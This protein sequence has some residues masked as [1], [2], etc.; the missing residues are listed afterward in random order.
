MQEHLLL[1]CPL[2]ATKGVFLPIQSLSLVE[3]VEIKRN[4]VYKD[5]K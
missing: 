5:V 3:T 2:S 1:S 4:R